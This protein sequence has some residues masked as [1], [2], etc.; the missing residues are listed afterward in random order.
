MKCPG[1]P[2]RITVGAPQVGNVFYVDEKHRFDVEAENCTGAPF[3]GE[4]VCRLTD[5][6]G[7]GMMLR[8][9]FAVPATASRVGLL[10][11]EDT[12]CVVG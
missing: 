12:P 11:G 9:P 1:F 10:A 3:A 8:R 7:T 4:T 2:L 6:E 5:I